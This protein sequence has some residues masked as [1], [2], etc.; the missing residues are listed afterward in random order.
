MNK[1]KLVIIGLGLFVGSTV[2][3]QEQK[4]ELKKSEP[5][6]VK[7]EKSSTELELTEEQK[8]EFLKLRK[9]S[10]LRQEVVRKDETL[11]EE[12]KS[13]KIESIQK[14]TKS[15]MI[16]TLTKEQKEKMPE[17]KSTQPIE[18]K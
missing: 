7:I 18:K 5:A 17:V 4:S 1:T 15:E 8:K 11:D 9:S 2:F 13:A 12:P 16:E 14:E 6:N 10:V 3:A